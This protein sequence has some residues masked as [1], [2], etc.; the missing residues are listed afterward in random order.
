M[1]NVSDPKVP[2]KPRSA[3]QPSREDVRAQALRDNLMRRKAQA[4]GRADTEADAPA[5]PAPV[6][7]D[8]RA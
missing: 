7:L 3:V 6:K 5:K 4:R 8:G 1:N 2:G